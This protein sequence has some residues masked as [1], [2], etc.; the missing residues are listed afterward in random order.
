MEMKSTPALKFVADISFDAATDMNRL[1]NSP[2]VKRDL[3]KK[4]ISYPR[5]IFLL[6]FQFPL[7]GIDLRRRE[8]VEH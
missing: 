1:F 8:R 5:Q 7:S 3:E 6:L 4:T 2:E